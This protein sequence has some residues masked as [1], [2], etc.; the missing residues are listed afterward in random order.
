MSMWPA[1][2]TRLVAL[3]GWPVDHSLSP[4]MHNAAFR[5]LGMDL[6]Y[7]AL[8][9]RPDALPTAVAGLAAIGAVGAN[10]TVPHKQA[11]V[12]LCDQLS[13]E[14]WLVGAVN[15]LSWTADGLVGHN[16]DALGLA[17]A[18]ADLGVAADVPAVI[19]GTGGAARAAVVA[20]ARAGRQVTVVGRRVEAAAELAALARDAGSANATS[21]QRDDDE[22][23]E[24]V[25]GAGLVLNATPLGMRGERLPGPFHRLRPGQ[26][27]FDLVYAP[28]QTPFLAD[29]RAAGAAAHGG[30]SMLVA[31]AELSFET[32]TG[33]TAPT[34]RMSA[35]AVAALGMG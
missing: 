26:V 13:D 14:A 33:S 9:V 20:L 23:A 7:V 12:G 11:V 32:W 17:R 30:I 24:V 2:S 3:L 4:A 28:A 18:L 5:E 10:V 29:A 34:G 31:Q 1:A 21:S 8:P 15:T 22:L 16:T 27:A 25:Q 35:A 19:L 6:V